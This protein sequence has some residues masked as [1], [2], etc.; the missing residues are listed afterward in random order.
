MLRMALATVALV[1]GCQSSNVSRVLGARCDKSAECDGRCLLAS[2][3]FPGGFCTTVC[4]TSSDCPTSDSQC[5]DRSGGACLFT[6]TDDAS[7]AFLGAGWVCRA[8]ATREQ[9]PHQVMIC[10]GA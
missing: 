7:C 6:C 10:S 3:G 2:D 8:A 4:D 1:V 9:P 5:V